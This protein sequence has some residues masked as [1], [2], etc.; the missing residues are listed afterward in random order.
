G[1]KKRETVYKLSPFLFL[2]FMPAGNEPSGHARISIWR[3]P[4]ESK[5]PMQHASIGVLTFRADFCLFC[6]RLG[7]TAEIIGKG[8]HIHLCSN[9]FL[10]RIRILSGHQIISGIADPAYHGDTYHGNGK[11]LQTLLPFFSSLD[12]LPVILLFFISV[13]FLLAHKNLLMSLFFY[14]SFC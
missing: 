11:L 6:I 1:G 14:K 3:M 9:H 7:K 12:L 4:Q 10:L 13:Y 8:S 5:T 2:I